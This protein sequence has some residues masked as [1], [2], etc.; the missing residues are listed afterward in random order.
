MFAPIVN[1]VFKVAALAPHEDEQKQKTPVCGETIEEQLKV[2]HAP[3][4]HPVAPRLKPWESHGT[5]HA[6]MKRH[7]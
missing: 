7:H 3:L 1:Q 5:Y 2:K 4:I 6:L